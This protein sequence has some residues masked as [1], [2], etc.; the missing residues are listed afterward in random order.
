MIQPLSQRDKRWKD[1]KLGNTNLTIGSDGCAL[2]AIG[3]IVG[4]TPDVVNER[5][6]QVG[7]FTPQGWVIWAKIDVA[8]PGIHARRVWSYDNEDVKANVKRVLVEVDGKPI[9]GA[10]HWVVYVG[11]QRLYDPWDGGIDP[12]SDYPNPLSYCV[13]EGVWEQ[14]AGVTTD[15]QKELDKTRTQRDDNHDDR[16]ALFG[17]LGGSGNFDRTWAITEIRQLK[18][19][20]KE[21]GSKDTVIKDLRNQLDEERMKLKKAQEEIKNIKGTADATSNVADVVK[22]QVEGGLDKIDEIG[23]KIDETVKNEPKPNIFDLLFDWLSQWKVR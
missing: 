23:K 13:L 15:I 21:S 9:G 11:S 14:G 22:I 8:F 18:E 3:I 4:T 16:M 7:G 20:A 10:R 5:L 17:E 19:I 12:T 2:T 6:K 1:I